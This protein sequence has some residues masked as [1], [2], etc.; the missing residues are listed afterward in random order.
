MWFS[1]PG[2]A[3]G[4]I[5]VNKPNWSDAADSS[6]GFPFGAS[7]PAWYL[8]AGFVVHLQ[9]AA[10]QVST[11]GPNPNL[12]GTLAGTAIPPSDV[13]TIAHTF[14]GT[15][16]DVAI[17]TDGSI[18]LIGPRSPA[19]QD[20]SFVSLESISYQLREVPGAGIP[21]NE[22]NWSDAADNTGFPFGARPPAWTLDESAPGVV[23]LQGAARQ[24][25][26]SG[27]NPNLLGTL[28]PAARPTRVVYTIAHTFN[29]TY[30]DLSIGTDGSINLIA[31]RSP[32][33]QGYSFVSLESISYQQ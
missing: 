19:V 29:G 9:G 20:Y 25:A 3:G 14:N 7:A 23:L 12:L 22:P 5:E 13:Y 4:L 15:S 17:G 24:A 11:S 31:P 1:V 8:D 27:A 16:V 32:A 26:T 28:P 2:P 18:N 30:A 21:L 6:T 33:V 10:G